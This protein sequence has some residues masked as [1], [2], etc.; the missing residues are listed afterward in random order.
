M[1]VS[2]EHVIRLSDSELTVLRACLSACALTV[3]GAHTLAQHLGPLSPFTPFTP[4]AP[5]GSLPAGSLPSHVLQPPPPPP[6]AG[7]LTDDGDAGAE[8]AALAALIAG[9]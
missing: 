2:T 6:G 7:H 9:R 3:P 1:Q 5:T 8:S 4:S